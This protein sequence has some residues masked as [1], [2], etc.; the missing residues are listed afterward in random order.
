MWPALV[1]A[2]LFMS[3]WR[4]YLEMENAFIALPELSQPRQVRITESANTHRAVL[5]PL[6]PP[7]QPPNLRD[8][9]SKNSL[10]TV[11]P[12]ELLFSFLAHFRLLLSSEELGLATGEA[13]K[14][15][16]DLE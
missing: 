2:K 14:L 15:I 1:Q 16:K 7:L 12:R 4:M 13:P 6:P 9:L 8:V 10:L 5:L 3:A 11:R